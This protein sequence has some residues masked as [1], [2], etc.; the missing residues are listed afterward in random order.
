[1][2]LA[3][4]A[5]SITMMNDFAEG[6]IIPFLRQSFIGECILFYLFLVL[7]YTM[8]KLISMGKKS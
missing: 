8:W 4:G 2:I 6:G 7:F 1:M 3:V 5:L